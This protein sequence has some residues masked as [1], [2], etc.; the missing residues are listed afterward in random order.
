QGCQCAGGNAHRP[1]P[2]NPVNRRRHKQTDR[3]T[4]QQ[5]QGR[6]PTLPPD[7]RLSVEFEFELEFEFEDCPTVWL[8]VWPT[9]RYTVPPTVGTP[10][11][12]AFSAIQPRRGPF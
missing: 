11:T 12:T 1:A 7:R 5:R 3:L 9:V 2:A 8:T 10:S 4:D 6:G